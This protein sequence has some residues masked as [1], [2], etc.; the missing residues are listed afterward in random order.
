MQNPQGIFLVIEGSDGSGKA[1]Q[2]NML[3]ERL[4]A[5]GYKVATFDF[6][7]YDQPSSHF[8]KKYLKGEYGPA[9]TISPYAAS[10][11]YAL[12]RY[13][14][15]K[16]IKKAIDDGYVVLSNRYVGSNM[17]HQGAKFK[18][19]I[20][21]RSFFVWEDSLEF[22]LL[23]IP[24]PNLN[25]FLK[26]PAETS[27]KLIAPKAK[28]SYTDKSHDEHEADMEHL[29]ASIKTY[30]LLCQLFPKDFQ[31]IDCTADG[32]LLSIEA[33]SKKVWDVIKPILPYLPKE[34][35][36]PPAT[37]E[38]EQPQKPAKTE[39][40]NNL[41]RN[42]SLAAAFELIRLGFNISIDS[43]S[44]WNGN[45]TKYDYYRPEALAGELLKTYKSSYDQAAKL[46]S[47]ITLKLREYYSAQGKS[48]VK[49]NEAA[50][51]VAL[52]AVPLGAIYEVTISA[53]EEINV[54]SLAR[55]KAHP[56]EEVAGLFGELQSLAG[57]SEQTSAE[58]Q[59]EQPESITEILELIGP[60][61]LPQNLSSEDFPKLVEVSPK[62]ELELLADHMYSFSD[63]SRD[64]ILSA[65]EHW[66][67]DQKSKAL[68]QSLA[69]NQ[70][71]LSLPYYRIDSLADRVSLANLMSVAAKETI[72]LQ[73]STVRYGYDVESIIE[74]AGVEDL[75]LEVFD[76]FLELFSSLQADVDDNRIE[77][78][79]LAGHKIRWQGRLTA[80]ELMRL[81]LKSQTE[82]EVDFAASLI[83]KVREVH[84][85]IADFISI[86]PAKPEA[87]ATKAKK[88][89]KRRRS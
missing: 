79:T 47:Q 16:E 78:A 25:V 18:D 9:S 34:E 33:I 29:K 35:D 80:V 19:E 6:P 83:D 61:R 62:N 39:V 21:K 4:E 14:A 24:R 57:I 73:Q 85:L 76:L 10:L 36:D 45:G 89:R 43:K 23:G 46:Q 48:K 20:E 7:R 69:A 68:R 74:A 86:K 32:D 27:Y 60:S 49:A 17:A 5:A 22:Q 8:V 72:R 13:E 59:T 88:T 11:F 31:E 53:S 3:K 56:N 82:T 87:K 67:Y 28:R 26:V 37:M 42:I 41:V 77:Y 66:S 70:S 84:P 64:E 52:R 54:D 38:Q 44:Y 51:E 81:N 40:A 71:I 50:A 63:L 58:T 65:M 1:T 55:I 12:D 2:F 15:G 75:F 30:D